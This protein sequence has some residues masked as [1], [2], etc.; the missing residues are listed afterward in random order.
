[1]AVL[2][3]KLENMLLVKFSYS[4]ERVSKIKSIK[5]YK[6]E[7]KKREWIIPHNEV[8][9]ILAALD[10]EKHKAILFLVY[11]AG[12]RVGKL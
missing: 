10:N 1:M 9:K 12:L 7:P 6:W 5:G 3:S 4:P 2:I 8:M 11:S